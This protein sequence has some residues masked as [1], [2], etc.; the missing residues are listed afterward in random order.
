MTIENVKRLLKHYQAVGN[1]TAVADML[2][3]RPELKEIKKAPIPELKKFPF[4]KKS[5]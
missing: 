3:H 1:H 2:K 4:K 5:K